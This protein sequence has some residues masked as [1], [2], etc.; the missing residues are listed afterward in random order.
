[1][2][3][4]RYFSALFLFFLIMGGFCSTTYASVPKVI[5]GVDVLVNSPFM[6]QLKGKRIGLVTNHTA[7]NYERKSTFDV[8]LEHAKRHRFSIAA[9]FAPEHGLTGCGHASESVVDA[10]HFQGVPIYS[11][12]GKTRRPTEEMLLG[13]DLIIYDI[14]DIG[15]RSYSFETTLFYVMEEAAKRKIPVMVLDRPNPIN[16]LVVDGPML[17]EK[18]R[19]MVGY[20][21]VPYCHGMTVGELA[22]LFNGEYKV[23]CS[24]TVIPMKGWERKMTFQETALPWVPTSP[25]IPEATTPLYYPMTGILGELQLVNIGVGYTL[26]FKVVGAPWIDAKQFAYH[27]NQQRFSGVHFQPFYYRPFYG[28]FAKK[29][30]QGVLIV[31]TDPLTYQ[32]V[33]I[34]YLI[35]GM[36]KSLY[37]EKFKEALV[38]ADTVNKE[39]FYKLNGTEEVYRIVKEDKHIVWK[40][41]EF[42][43][44]E[45]ESFLRLRKK[46]L[47][48]SY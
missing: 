13:I 25:Y 43:Q 27:L 3:H 16:G 19:S 35:I 28:R 2:N 39:M 37:P 6:Q 34:Q 32:P 38:A 12:H 45:R 46:Y 10:K 30:C 44:K 15:S 24:L 40:L 31:V 33:S 11:L 5:V 9:L 21:N 42:Q 26:P 1:M 4:W 48:A 23:Q 36:L 17:E 47:I 29:E 41:K 20:V 14:Q 22:K 18:W 8:L 7:I